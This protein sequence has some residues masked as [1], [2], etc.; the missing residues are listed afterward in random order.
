LAPAAASLLIRRTLKSEVTTLPQAPI[1]V[2]GH[3]FGKPRD[4]AISDPFIVVDEIYDAVAGLLQAADTRIGFAQLRFE[5]DSP[6][7]GSIASYLARRF[8]V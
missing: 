4:P 5:D 1:R 3:H 7:R 2:L 8:N 6:R